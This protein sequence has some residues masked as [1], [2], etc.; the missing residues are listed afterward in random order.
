MNHHDSVKTLTLRLPDSLLA[1]LEQEARRVNLSKS[2]LVRD[3]LQQHQH[4]RA[5]NALDLAG[6]LCGCVD[7]GLRDLSH[8]KKRLKGFGQ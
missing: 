5:Q 6:D 1:W 7:S 2:A 8:N 4:Q 3:V